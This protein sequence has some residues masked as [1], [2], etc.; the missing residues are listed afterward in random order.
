MSV[1]HAFIPNG[2]TPRMTTSP[3]RETWIKARI[4]QARE[5]SPDVSPHA[6]ALLEGLL[7]GQF[8]EQQLP[9]KKLGEIADTLLAEGSTE[10]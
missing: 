8:V 6:V 1:D 4:R 3:S 7:A 9:R 2:A 10:T 5:A